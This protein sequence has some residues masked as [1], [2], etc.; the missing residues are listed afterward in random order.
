[1]VPWPSTISQRRCHEANILAITSTQI[2]QQH[3][4]LPTSNQLVPVANTL[5]K[6][7]QSVLTLPSSIKQPY[8]DMIPFECCGIC[9]DMLLPLQRMLF[10]MDVHSL[11]DSTIDSRFHTKPWYGMWSST[12]ENLQLDSF[13]TIGERKKSY[14][15]LFLKCVAL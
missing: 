14:H 8:I 7:V 12:R 15:P 4:Q 10:I 2:T 11:A 9:I 13:S 3:Q 5:S 1:V 6:D